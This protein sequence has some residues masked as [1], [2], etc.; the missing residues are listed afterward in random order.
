MSS[1]KKLP[2]LALGIPRASVPAHV[3]RPRSRWPSSPFPVA[4]QS[5]SASADIVSFT[6][7]S[8]SCLGCPR[9]FT[10]PSSMREMAS[11]ASGAL[12]SA[13]PFIA[14]IALHQNLSCG[15]SDSRQWPFVLPRSQ[16]QAYTSI[17]DAIIPRPLAVFPPGTATPA[18]STLAKCA[19]I[20]TVPK[21]NKRCRSTA[22]ASAHTNGDPRRS[23]HE[24]SN[25]ASRNPLREFMFIS[26]L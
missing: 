15:N 26:I 12:T 22:P 7:D 1:G 24:T 3:T 14:V 17:P 9:V 11:A 5:R 6:T 25:Y 21:P 13:M 20:L 18:F 19:R 10:N 2:A 8:A 4:S 16:S 23:R